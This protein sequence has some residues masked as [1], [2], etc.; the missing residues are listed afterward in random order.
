[1]RDFNEMQREVLVERVS[2]YVDATKIFCHAIDEVLHDDASAWHLA[3][4]WR[5]NTNRAAVRMVV[6]LLAWLK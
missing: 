3:T 4:L 2:E 5:D 1:M 6:S